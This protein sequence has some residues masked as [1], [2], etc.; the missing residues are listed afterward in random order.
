MKNSIVLV[1]VVLVLPTF[2]ETTLDLL[3]GKTPVELEDWKPYSFLSARH[4]SIATYAIKAREATYRSQNRV[5]MAL[6][7]G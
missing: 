3:Q 4:E 1:P 2:T 7:I 6:S 5:G